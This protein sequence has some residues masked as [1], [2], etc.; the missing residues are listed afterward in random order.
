VLGG[1]NALGTHVPALLLLASLLALVVWYP[2]SKKR[3]DENVA[4]LAER[5]AAAAPAAG[6]ES[7]ST[8][9]QP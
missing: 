8:S 1:I 3:V 5:H 7:P 4:I 6:E 2:L 9:P